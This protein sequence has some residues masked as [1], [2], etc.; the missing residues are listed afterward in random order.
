MKQI[1]RISAIVL[2]IVM[3]FS[4]SSCS[5]VN[6]SE[7]DI[8]ND[9]IKIGIILADTKDSNIG[10]AGICNNT[11]NQLTSIGCGIGSERFHYV[12]SVDP[13]DAN[14][15]ANAYNTLI[16]FECNLI[17][18]SD[19]GYMD[20]TTAV[21]DANQSI[22]F[23][24]MNGTGNGN[25]IFGYQ[26]NVTGAAY[27]EGIVAG[28]KA[29]DLK[30]PMLGFI[31]KNANDY[32]TLNAFYAGAK[33]VNDD[34]KTNVV[35][36]GNDIEADAKK[37]T[38]AG[39]VVIAS[40]IQSEEIAKAATDAKVFFCGYGTDAFAEDYADA[41]LC[42]VMYDYTQYFVDTIKTIVDY[43]LPDESQ[44]STIELIDNE[45]LIA[46]YNG[47]LKTGAT[48]ISDI[49]LANAPSGDANTI[50]KTAEKNIFDGKLSFE[51]S[52]SALAEGITIVK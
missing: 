13:D 50:V 30:V 47:G 2:A 51:V 19:P 46:D 6:T 42:S 8:T 3:I 44:Q 9:N 18:A 15:V 52:A 43:E 37:L 11:I 20:D 36:A 45:K 41:Y 31:L 24:V 16:N 12:E 35:V 27:L 40:D 28:M 38:D 10:S 23:F 29:A 1:K 25:N 49:S 26:A 33:S 22:A 34:V 17:I 4:F 5:L 39:C 48:Y 7:T 14:A 32:T 21:A